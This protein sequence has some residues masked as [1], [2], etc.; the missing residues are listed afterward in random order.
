M[1][2]R[3]QLKNTTVGVVELIPPMVDTD[4]LPKNMKKLATKL[5]PFADHVMAQLLEGKEEIIFR[6]EKLTQG[7]RE[8]SDA[9]FKAIN[10][11]MAADK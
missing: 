4:F 10:P 5:D 6:T 8:Q 7:S 11:P 2:L 9:F 3:H 1:S